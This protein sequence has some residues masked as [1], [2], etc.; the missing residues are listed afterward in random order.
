MKHLETSII[1]I[2]PTA[3]NLRAHIKKKY[4]EL[5][6]GA[7]VCGLKNV[8]IVHSFFPVYLVTTN[9]KYL[10]I[11]ESISLY[12]FLFLLTILSKSYYLEVNGNPITGVK[13]PYILKYFFSLFRNLLFKLN[14]NCN[15][16]SY[17]K[18]EIKFLPRQKYIITS[19]VCSGLLYKKTLPRKKSVVM[20]IGLDVSYQGVN[21]LRFIAKHFPDYSFYV[22]GST[23]H[24]TM[25]N[26]FF[27]K[28]LASKFIFKNYNFGYA[29]GSLNY[30]KK[31][32]N[33]N[34]SLKGVIYH[35]HDLPFIQSFKENFS[36]P[37]FVLNIYSF[38]TSKSKLKNIKKFFNYWKYRNLTELDLEVFHPKN[39]WIRIRKFEQEN[40]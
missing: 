38:T 9:Y 26:V 36:A 39:Y 24:F 8:N 1:L 23:S 12:P 29:I 18:S 13:Y 32:I 22:F 34:S 19:N 31:N 33:D 37:R 7:K 14:R 28:Y 16:I 25:P 21:K 30:K 27:Y 20:L 5:K 3:K 10:I 6:K 4:E 35:Q 11:R 40:K 17:S 2:A 15:I